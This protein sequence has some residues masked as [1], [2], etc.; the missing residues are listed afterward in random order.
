[1]REMGMLRQQSFNMT[2]L[3]IGRQSAEHA[4]RRIAANFGMVPR[5]SKLV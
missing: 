5:A 3:P 2:E 1:M 4:I